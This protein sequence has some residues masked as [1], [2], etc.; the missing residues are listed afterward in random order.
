MYTIESLTRENGLYCLKHH[1]VQ[2]DVDKVNA[3]VAAIEGARKAA[4]LTPLP[5]DTVRYSDN[6]G[7]YYEHALIVKLNALG[8]GKAELCYSPFIPNVHDFGDGTIAINCGGGASGYNDT[9]EFVYA[10]QGLR[11]FEIWGS[12]GPEADGMLEFQARV[13]LWVYNEQNPMFGDYSTKT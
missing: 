12:C 10:G 11:T 1:V 3:L 9:D 4:P 2:S 13:N 7:E 6:Y 5:G 8:D